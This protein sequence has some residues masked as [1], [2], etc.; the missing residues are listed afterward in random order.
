MN[1]RDLFRRFAPAAF[2][3]V[4]YLNRA[5]VKAEPAVDRADHEV[6]ARVRFSE[7]FVEDSRLDVSAV[8]DAV[9]R[10]LRQAVESEM[11]RQGVRISRGLGWVR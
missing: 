3:P 11:A 9:Q 5:G 2:V 8:S 1:R 10:S 7:F 6:S 4:V